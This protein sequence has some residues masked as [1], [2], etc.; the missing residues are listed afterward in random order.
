MQQDNSASSNMMSSAGDMFTPP[1]YSIFFHSATSPTSFNSTPVNSDGNSG[2]NTDNISAIALR[3]LSRIMAEH[4]ELLSR[5]SVCLA[6]LQKTFNEA[7]TLRQENT[8]LRLENLEL[9]NQ[10]DLLIE[11]SL[12]S[13]YLAM[14]FSDYPEQFGSSSLSA[15][16][17]KLGGGNG[18]S[19]GSFQK[20]RVSGDW[21]E[22]F[23]SN[24]QNRPTVNEKSQKEDWKE[25]N[26]R[27][28]L[29]KSISVRSNGFVKM[30]QIAAG[31]TQ[32]DSTPAR[33]VTPLRSSGK[34]SG[35]QKVYVRG[36]S[37][38]NGPIELEV[39]NQGMFKT[40]LCNKWQETKTCP[41]GDHCQFAHGIEELRPVIRH[42]RYKTEVCRMVLAGD[43]CPYGH[44]CHFRHA[45]TDEEKLMH[46]PRLN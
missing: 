6:Q 32:K 36:G 13:R 38:K 2:R 9:S 35:P 14:P 24:N 22:G 4:K 8:N 20:E 10:L 42:P 37:N 26:A 30:N 39:Y 7:E 15:A 1:P 27:V 41:Y 3:S 28:A 45:L 44:R 18:S 5:H 12:Q 31:S 19:N 23:C 21:D 17:E 11:D 25:E 46:S 34:V 33:S 16:A 43:P 40:E 29:P